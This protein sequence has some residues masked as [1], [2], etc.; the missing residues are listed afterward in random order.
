MVPV[1][2]SHWCQVTDCCSH[3]LTNALFTTHQLTYQLLSQQPVT[4]QRSSIY[5]LSIVV[6]S[7]GIFI[8]KG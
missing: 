7:Y 8:N 2:P 5:E 1:C 3:S 4:C 6:V